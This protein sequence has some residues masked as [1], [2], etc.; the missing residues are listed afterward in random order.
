MIDNKAMSQ[1]HQNNQNNIQSIGSNPGEANLAGGNINNTINEG[2]RKNLTESAQEIQSLLDQLSQ[3]YP[4]STPS[5]QMV[6]ATEAISQIE[7]NPNLKT[8]IIN[9]LKSAGSEGL[10]ELVNRPLFN[11]LMAAIEG[12]R[13]S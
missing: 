4:T 7:N 12:W 3:T 8:K 1:P 13:D 2:E 9:A 11:I 10:K 6:V 5:E